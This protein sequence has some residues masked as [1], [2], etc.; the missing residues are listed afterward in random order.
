MCKAEEREKEGLSA[1]KE[2]YEKGYKDGQGR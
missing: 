2:G 1:Y